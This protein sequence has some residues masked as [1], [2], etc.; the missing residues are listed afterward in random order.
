M[1]SFRSALLTLALAVSLLSACS[2][3]SNPTTEPPPP[4]PQALALTRVVGGQLSDIVVSDPL[5]YVATGRVIAVWDY[6]DPSAPAQVGAVNEPVGGLIT[7]L[8]VHGDHMYASWRTGNDQS[9]V[10]IYALTDPAQPELVNEIPISVAFSHVGAIAA[11]NDHIYLFDSE[12]GIWV[13]SLADPEAP[14]FMTDGTGLGGAFDRTLVDGNLIYVFGK[15]FIGGAV[16]TTYDVSTPEA[17]QE[18][19]TF[20]ADGI[21]IFDLQFNLPLAVGFGAKLSVLDL[22]NPNAVVPRGSADTFAMTGIVN[23]THAYGVGIDGLDVWD[24]Q[25]PDN[26]SLVTNLE[27]DTLAAASAATVAGGALMLTSTDRFVVLDTANPAAPNVS[28]DAVMPGSV[29]AYDAARVGDTVLFLQQNYG[30]ALADSSTLE[31]VGRHEFD[32]P[33][34]LQERVFSDMQVDGDVAYLAAWGFG[35]I[36]ADVSDPRVP[37][38]I[39]RLPAVFAHTVAVADG[40]AYIAKNT[41]GPELGIIDVSDRASPAFLASY[42]LPFTPAQLAARGEIVYVAGYPNGNLASVGLR[43]FDA[44]DPLNAVELGFYDEDC[45]S[46]FEVKLVD[47]LA[48]LACN[49]GLHIVDASDP[50]APLRVGYAEAEDLNDVRTSLEVRGDH[51]WYGNPAG[52]IELDISDSANPNELATTEIGFYGPINLRAIDDNR[53]LAMMGI[54][55][56]HVFEGT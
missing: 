34:S 4:P 32:L 19:Q 30:L 27:I 35:L 21:D 45:A 55:G 43:M 36:L 9:G 5:A 11:A 24:I 38:E 37:A 8:A 25:D 23:A 3:S 54:A 31:V 29:D 53:V 44:S 17:P 48:Y 28:G 20:V 52:I 14:T 46:A 26:P 12:N 50:T 56:I 7:G 6:G 41:N 51:A 22:S 10:T 47:D 49:N 42:A 16:L 18:L 15:S 13:G 40:R 33:A 1:R 2:D 39:A